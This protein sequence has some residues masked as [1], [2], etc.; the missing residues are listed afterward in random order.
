M[1]R[2]GRCA[3]LKTQKIIGWNTCGVVEEIGSDVSL[4]KLGDRVFYVGSFIR[5]GSDSEYQLFD[6]RIVGHAPKF[7]KIMEQSQCL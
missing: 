5:S 3:V 1:V 4:F 2:K 7:F 6:E